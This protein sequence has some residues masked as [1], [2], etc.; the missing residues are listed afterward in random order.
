MRRDT[1]RSR[2]YKCDR[3]LMATAGKL[4]EVRDVERFVKKVFASK[5]VQDA[6]PVAARWAIPQ[7]KDGRARTR[8][9]GGET[10]I[11]IPRWARDEAVVLHELAHTI[12]LRDGGRRGDE[13]YHGWRFCAIYLK[14]VLYLMGREAHDVLKAA[15][16]ENRVRFTAPRKSKPM[17]PA[18]KAA[19]AARLA[20]YRAGKAQAARFAGLEFTAD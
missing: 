11:A 18:R 6:F 7:V 4:P 14:L 16:K 17:D 13:A 1:Q 10:S 8:A 12:H 3:I 15:F 20:S 5:R 2:V 9:C 19:L